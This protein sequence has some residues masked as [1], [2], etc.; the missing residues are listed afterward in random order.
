MN[1]RRVTIKDIAKLAGVSIGTVSRAINN[2]GYV[3]KEARSNIELAIKNTNYVPSTTARSMINRKSNIVGIVVPE[4]NNPFLA[5]LVVKIEDILSKRNY[6]MMLCNSSYEH[7]KIANFI[8]DLIMRSAEGIIL[9]STDV[10]DKMV[11]RKLEDYLKVI[12][13]GQH[14]D[15]FDCVKLTDYKSAFELTK[16]IISLG[17]TKIALLGY[18]PNATQTVERLEGYKAALINSDIT[19][20]EEY[21]IK[22][23]SGYDSTKHLLHLPERPTAIVAI[24]DFYA[25]EAYAAVEECG[26]IVGENISIVGFDDILV[27]RFLKPTLTTVRCSTLQIAKSATSLLFNNIKKGTNGDSTELILPS[28]V[29]IRQSVKKV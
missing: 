25:L 3:G 27:A 9:V 18:H 6:S 5:D 17:H 26:L 24:N 11:I 28:E 19:P 7:G 29:V 16:Y 2:S 12:S 4:I 13:V 1:G 22:A 14:L 20:C 8:D 10:H 15:N 23:K 21:I